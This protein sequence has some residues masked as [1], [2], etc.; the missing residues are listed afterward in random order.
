[1]AEKAAPKKRTRSYHN[2][3][4]TKAEREKLEPHLA[5]FRKA[6]KEGRRQLLGK[7]VIPDLYDL[8]PNLDERDKAELKRVR[9]PLLLGVSC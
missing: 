3:P 1:M 6:D 4:W 8:H 5:T 7:T 9:K 2:S